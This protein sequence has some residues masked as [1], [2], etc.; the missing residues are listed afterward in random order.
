MIGTSVLMARANGLST[1]KFMGKLI[2]MSINNQVTY[3]LGVGACAMGSQHACGSFFADP[4]TAHTNKVMVATLPYE[5]KRLTQEI[6]GGIAETGCMPS[7]RDL[8][9]PEYGALLRRC[10][11]AGAP[12]GEARFKS[13]RL[14]EWLTVGAGIPGCMH[15]GGS[16]DGA[17]LVVRF[18]TPWEEYVDYAKKI[19]GIEEEVA[20]P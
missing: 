19:M 8:A 10:L 14:A 13:A 6:G 5:V 2:D 12:S 20:E 7:Y 11:K 15:G 17:K 9:N 1:S 18:T 3:G 16:P 4:L